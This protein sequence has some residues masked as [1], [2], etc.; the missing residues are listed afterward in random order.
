[1]ALESA[2]YISDLDASNPTAGDGRNQGDDHIR[3]IKS[4]IKNTFPSL[5]AAVTVTATELNRLSGV[6]S[7]VQTQL[8]TLSSDV[9]N[10]AAKGTNTDITSLASP[11]LANA[12]ANTQTAGDNTTKVATTQFVTSA[13][14][15]GVSTKANDSAVVHLAGTETVTGAK[16]FSTAPVA[17]NIAKVWCN[18]DGTATPDGSGNLAFTGYGVS[19]VHKDGTGNYTVNFSS[20]LADAEYSALISG[21][22]LVYEDSSPARTTSSITITA[23]NY[24]TGTA[25]NPPQVS[26]AIFR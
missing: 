22:G 26:L 5:S 24:S 6:T 11:A 16:T 8:N 19:T 3:L 4:A 2:T 25:S 1:M 14:S 13:V 7:S 15:T 10:K 17:T 12:T 9:S 23:V 21:I 18:F 20:A